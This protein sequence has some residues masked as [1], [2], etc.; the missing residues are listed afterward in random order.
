MRS[1]LLARIRAA[2]VPASHVQPETLRRESVQRLSVFAVSAM[3][4]IA[5]QLF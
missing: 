4:G 1:F 3:V 5:H 2:E